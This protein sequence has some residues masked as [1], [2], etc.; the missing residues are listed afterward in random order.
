[1][2]KS[3]TF[4]DLV[5]G[6]AEVSVCYE[7]ATAL[8]FMDLQPVNPGHVLVV[9]RAHY[10]SLV[11]V[12]PR[13]ATHLFE[14]ALKLGGVVRRVTG[15]EGTNIIVNS[16]AAAGQD[17]FH[18]HVHVIPRRV[19]DGFSIELPF[20]GSEM[21]DR[22]LLDAMAAQIITAM[23]DPM[24]GGSGDARRSPPRRASGEKRAVAPAP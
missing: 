6:A 10:E 17:I 16:G 5:L 21:P 9:P 7:D 19:G 13:V 14:V 20:N 3:C 8:A 24:R 2:T 11:D 4:C 12:P 22:R 18:Y 23:S 1:M 15:T